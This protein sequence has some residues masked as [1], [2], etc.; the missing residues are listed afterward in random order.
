MKLNSLNKNRPFLFLRADEEE[1]KLLFGG[2]QMSQNAKINA[3]GTSQIKIY[4][5]PSG[6]KGEKTASEIKSEEELLPCRLILYCTAAPAETEEACA[7]VGRRTSRGTVGRKNKR[8]GSSFSSSGRQTE[9]G[10]CRSCRIR[11]HVSSS[12]SRTGRAAGTQSHVPGGCF[13]L[14]AGERWRVNHGKK[15]RLK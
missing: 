14:F 4:F 10:S 13:V 6:E 15:A 7:A 9:R 3:V 12:S 2:K 5:F 1:T 11:S 8:C